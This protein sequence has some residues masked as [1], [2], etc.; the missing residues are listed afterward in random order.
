LTVDFYLVS[1]FLAISNIFAA[2]HYN[3]G[4]FLLDKTAKNL[5]L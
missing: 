5:I 4:I 1:F 3:L 2:V